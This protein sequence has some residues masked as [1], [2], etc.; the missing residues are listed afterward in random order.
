MLR[1]NE[2]HP[3]NFW[4]VKSL[5]GNIFETGKMCIAIGCGGDRWHKIMG[6]RRGCCRAER[7][8]HRG[9]RQRG[10]ECRRHS[11]S[12]VGIVS[13]DCAVARWEWQWEGVKKRETRTATWRLVVE[14]DAV[15]GEKAV[16]LAVVEH[17]VVR[18]ELGH[19]VRRARV[20]RRRLGLRHLA[21][22]PVQLRARRLIEA[23]LLRQAHRAHRLQ[24]TQ[25]PYADTRNHTN[26]NEAMLTFAR[27]DRWIIGGSEIRD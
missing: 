18:E 3:P 25:A 16:R 20:E 6:S 10:E 7:R 2:A 27:I 26:W 22:L 17:D 9:E 5:G 24:Q 23:H 1:F 21:H 13:V 11:G 15:G 19:R 12:G 14:E 4:R 8:R